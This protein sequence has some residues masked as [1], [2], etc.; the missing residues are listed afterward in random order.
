MNR[1]E[2]D[3]L[4]NYLRKQGDILDILLKDRTTG[5]NIIW[6]TDSYVTTNRRDD[7]FLPRKQIL[8][9]YV[10]G[11]KYGKLIQPRVAK[12]IEEQKRRTKDKAEVFTPLRIVDQMNKSIDWSM[13]KIYPV[14]EKNW[15]EYVKS[16]RL[17]ITCGIQASRHPGSDP[18]KLKTLYN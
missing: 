18:V 16:P 5:H 11:P 2:A 7:P 6:A 8:S 13:E 15:Q 1:G 3:I 4:E 12:S 17:E 10:T 9:K 14:N